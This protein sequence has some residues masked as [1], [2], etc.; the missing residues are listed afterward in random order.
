MIITN[1][2]DYVSVL[3]D[4]IITSRTLGSDSY[5][6]IALFNPLNGIILLFSNAISTGSHVVC[7]HYVGTADKD[8]ANSV[9]SVT[10]L[11]MA[12]ASF[13]VV[14]FWTFIP[15]A[16]IRIAGLSSNSHPQL[17]SSMIGYING[18]MFGIPLL[19]IIQVIGPLIVMD[20]GK[21]LF[22]LSAFSMCVF[23][24]IGNLL[25][26][27][28]IH[29]GT[30]GMGLST[31]LAYLLQFA[32]L[33]T[34]FLRHKGY[35]GF[36]LS[37][38]SPSQ[39]I[40]I[41]RAGSP[42][43]VRKLANSL[44]DLFIN[45]FNLAI[46]LTTAAVAAK[47]IQN[48]IN[49]V[50]F[51]LG[52]GIGKTLITMTGIY[53][54]ADDR[55]GIT[56]LFTY[57]MKI[58]VLLSGIAGAVIFIAAPFIAEAFSSEQEVINLAVFSIRCMALGILPDTIVSALMGYFQAV[59]SSKLLNII[60]I[61]D[62]FAAPI[63]SA[64]I[65]GKFFGTKGIMASMAAGKILVIIF[66]IVIVWIRTKRFPSHAEDF[67]FLPENFGGNESNNI[68]AS[69]STTDE[70]LSESRKAE[71]FCIMHGV[72]SRKAKLMSL[73]IEEMA[74]NI[75]EH[76]LSQRR[77][78]IGADYR[79]SLSNKTLCLTLRDYCERFDPVAFY[80]AHINEPSENMLGISIV[81]KLAKDKR[82]FNAFN[83]NNIIISIDSE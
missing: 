65:L 48:D 78:K 58:S 62:R 64:V 36:S 70:A 31:S 29:G 27:L 75:V 32:I 19:M 40:E 20:G 73:F 22:T 56:R 28:V 59:N 71:D 37:A 39:L 35:F 49:T 63:I 34:H 42:T 80:N 43:F 60:N 77:R 67:M 13:L 11:I 47:G 24:I 44:R 15:D 25:N 72:N 51:C 21:T 1:L 76:G 3:I 79:L 16:L 81:M 41:I 38:F 6:A 61:A 18:F 5:S 12:I 33:M 55:H 17:Y 50:M 82:Y 10:L 53:Y 74:V 83:S 46:A 23:N 45:R 2:V 14:M 69:I 26:G 66:I 7:S 4:G 8:K 52:L 68:Y 30:F 57:S 9:F 54:G